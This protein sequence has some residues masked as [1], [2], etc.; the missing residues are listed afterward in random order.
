MEMVA[1]V[2]LKSSHKDVEPSTKREEN[3]KQYA[4]RSDPR[5]KG[6][7]RSTIW[8]WNTDN[9][10]EH[11]LQCRSSACKA[12]LGRVLVAHKLGEEKIVGKLFHDQQVVFPPLGM[13]GWQI[14]PQ[15]LHQPL[16]HHSFSHGLLLEFEIL[17]WLFQCTI[18]LIP[19]I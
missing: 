4:S 2:K 11:Q 8:K 10:K 5:Q 3:E 17:H 6:V 13:T 9:E 7:Q 14:A 18:Q 1:H 15:F 16:G 19:T 12:L